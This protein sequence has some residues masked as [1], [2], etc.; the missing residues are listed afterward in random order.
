MLQRPKSFDFWAFSLATPVDDACLRGFQRLDRVI[1]SDVVSCSRR[2]V[3]RTMFVSAIDLLS[4]LPSALW[5][6][7]SQ[8]ATPMDL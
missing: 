6:R 7:L 4:E 5:Q 8:A 2:M 1:A 3:A